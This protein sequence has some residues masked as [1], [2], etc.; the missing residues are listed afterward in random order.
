MHSQKEGSSLEKSLQ[1]A[2][3]LCMV[4]VAFTCRLKAEERNANWEPGGRGWEW[5]EVTGW[6]ALHRV[7]SQLEGHRGLLPTSLLGWLS[8][9][10]LSGRYSIR[11]SDWVLWPLTP[12]PHLKS[13]QN[14]M[15]SQRAVAWSPA[16]C[17]ILYLDS[18]ITNPPRHCSGCSVWALRLCVSLGVHCGCR[19]LLQTQGDQLPHGCLLLGLRQPFLLRLSG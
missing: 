15:G 6:E 12:T 10:L 3:L 4:P 7:L 16:S 1:R 11:H 18:S 17:V 13:S 8:L 5:D 9:G 2:M 19:Q 14:P